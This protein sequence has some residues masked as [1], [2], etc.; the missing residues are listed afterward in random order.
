MFHATLLLRWQRVDE[1]F[2]NMILVFMLRGSDGSLGPAL[3]HAAAATAGIVFLSCFLFCELHLVCMSI[4]N[5]L[6]LRRL[7][8][9]MSAV[10]RSP[11]CTPQFSNTIFPTGKLARNFRAVLRMP[12]TIIAYC[13]CRCFVLAAGP[14]SVRAAAGAALQPSAARCMALAVCCSSGRCIRM[15]CCR[16]C[17]CRQRIRAGCGQAG[18]VAGAAA[19]LGLV[20]QRCC[21]VEACVNILAELHKVSL[22]SIILL[23]SNFLAT[24]SLV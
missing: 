15:R 12:E 6:L 13:R 16:L 22:Q 18:A 20:A 21:L 24:W 1:T 10:P 5:I 7:R 14:L 17:V 9:P 2:E 23:S 8:L 19:A 4:A 3:L 11:C